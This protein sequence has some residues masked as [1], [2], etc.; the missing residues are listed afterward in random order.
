MFIGGCAGSTTCGIKIFRF[1]I[2]Y[3]FVVNQLKKIIYPRGIFIIKYD[4]NEVDEK[5]ISSIISF[6]FFYF[7]IFFTLTALL[8][9]NG[10]DFITSVSGAATSI[11]NVGPGLGSIIGPNGN[12]SSLSDF[13]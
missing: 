1:Q 7:V 8:S 10:L 9:L 4:Q 5:F 3:L 13:S 11:S 2:L 12:F 6:I